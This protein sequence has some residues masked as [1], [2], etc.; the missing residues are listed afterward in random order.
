VLTIK[1]AFVTRIAISFVYR[2]RFEDFKTR[3][4][5]LQGWET[6][7]GYPT[8]GTLHS[9]GLNHVADELQQLAKLGK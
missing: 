1:F 8:A 7:N 5:K 3:F 9:M 2:D 4:Y 6:S